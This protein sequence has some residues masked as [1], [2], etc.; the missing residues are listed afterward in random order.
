MIADRTAYNV[1]YTGNYQFQTGFRYK[2]QVDERLIRMIG[3]N[4]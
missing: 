4:G 1:Q 2:L 3:F